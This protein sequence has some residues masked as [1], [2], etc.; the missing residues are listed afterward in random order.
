MNLEYQALFDLSAVLGMLVV[1]FLFLILFESRYPTKVYLASLIPFLTLWVGGNLYLLFAY[2]ANI[3]GRWLLLTCTLTSLLYFFLVA[4]HRNGRFFCTFCLVDTAVIWIMVATNLIDYVLGAEGLAAF[5]LRLILFP[6][7]ALAA[8]RFGRQPYLSLLHTASRGWWMF[9]AMAGLFY[10][11]L[12]VMAGIPVN[13]R[14][15]PE[16]IPAT[17]MV[18][19]LMPLTYATI[20]RML[21]QQNE[22]FRARERQHAF[23]IQS[24]MMEQRVG[25]LQGEENRL[26]VERHDL[27]HRL[28][29]ISAM[30]QE[31]DI[32]AALDYIGASRQ[33]LDAT[34]VERYCSD[35]A[36]DAILGS[37]FRQAKE[38][39][40]RLETRIELPD[41][42]PVPS[43]ELSTVFA[44]ALEN[45][46]NAVRELPAEDRRMIC[47]CISTPCLMMEFSNPCRPDVRLGPDGLP[48]ARSASHGI[49]TRSIAAFAEKYQAVCDFQVENG[50][51]KLRLAL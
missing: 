40:V 25:E 6:M 24:A 13:L 51:F 32:Q 28:L 42:L 17:A 5:V 48:V 34:E 44:N 12:C 14:L 31:N 21:Y 43:A 33:A 26:R 27:R 4:K 7:I 16:A 36:L 45:M 2:G 39:G 8:W 50:W 37:Y 19:L 15:R 38:L 9:A 22:L 47:K 23:E 10:V 20:F 35:P 49:G 11:T 29:A 1:V 3:L 41:K 46:I 18:L 30:L